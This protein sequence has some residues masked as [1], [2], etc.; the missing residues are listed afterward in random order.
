MTLSLG[1]LIGLPVAG[2]LV[3]V[4]L[5][6]IALAVRVRFVD[7]DWG[8]AGLLAAAAALAM[9]AIVAI[10]GFA[11]WPWTAEYHEWQPV[12]GTVTDTSSR[13]LGDDKSTSQY[14]AM[15]INGQTYRC[16]DTRC[17]TVKTGDHL[18]LTCKREWQFAG[19]PGWDCN[20]VDTTPATGHSGS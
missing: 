18:D 13:L 2:L 3:L 1:V 4:C 15:E 6:V 17:A 9:V 20:F 11:M 10:T 14:Y 16:D 7:G 12:A 8:D 5:V 19:T